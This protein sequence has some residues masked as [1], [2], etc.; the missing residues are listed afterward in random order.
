[1]LIDLFN[2]LI[3]GMMMLILLANLSWG[4]LMIVVSVYLQFAY[5]DMKKNDNCHWFLSTIHYFLMT[6]LA[7]VAGLCFYNVFSIAFF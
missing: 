7:S 3:W 4:M 2:D 5:N 6:G 1:M